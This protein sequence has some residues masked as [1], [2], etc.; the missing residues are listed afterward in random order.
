MRGEGGSCWVPQP[1]STAVHRSPNKLRR[2]RHMGTLGE[3][4]R[5]VGVPPWLVRW[6]RRA[7]TIVFCPCPAQCKILFSSPHTFSLYYIV[8]IA[9]Q[10]WAGS[11]AGSP[12][13]VSL[14]I[15]GIT[16]SS[17]KKQRR[18]INLMIRNFRAWVKRG[19]L[20][21]TKIIIENISFT[22]V[23]INKFTRERETRQNATTFW[24]WDLFL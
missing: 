24:L 7:G 11:R 14:V 9:Q 16:S 12:V 17:V 19:F 1:M 4:M 6:A 15:F 10:T 22:F 21:N 2:S 18:S 20:N 3:H 8:P 13:S 5:G 23:F